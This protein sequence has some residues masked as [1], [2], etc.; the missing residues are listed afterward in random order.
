MIPVIEIE[1][2]TCAYGDTEVVRDLSLQVPEGSTYAFLGTNGA[3]KTTTIKTLLNLLPAT[4]GTAKVLGTS[5]TQLGPQ[6]LAQIGY[7]SGDQK[8]PET[9]TVKHLINYS[10][11][12]YP[13][14]DDIFCQRLIQTLALPLDRKVTQL[15]TGMKVKAALLLALAFRPRL[16]ILGRT[17]QRAGSPGAR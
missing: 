4:R 11:A 2:L 9:L 5:V 8:L 6:E 13:T 7:L 15:S 10:R 1:H 14:W 3:G 16:L 12:I 17:F